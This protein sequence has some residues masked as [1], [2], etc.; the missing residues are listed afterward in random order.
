MALRPR[1][2]KLD[3]CMSRSSDLARCTLAAEKCEYTYVRASNIIFAINI[4]ASLVEDA[5]SVKVEKIGKTNKCLVL[6]VVWG[7]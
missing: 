4:D 5:I 3:P 7:I 1:F 2:R 6:W